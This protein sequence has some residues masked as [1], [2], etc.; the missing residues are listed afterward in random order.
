MSDQPNLPPNLPATT[1][2]DAAWE[3]EPPRP[4][5]DPDLFDGILWRRAVGYGIDV[6]LLMVIFSILGL[7]A[8]LY[9]MRTLL[10]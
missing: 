6:L 9:V 2:R 3:G 10:A 4:L 7:F 1:L 8:G 5:E